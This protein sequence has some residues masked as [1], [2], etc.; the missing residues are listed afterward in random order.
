M[1]QPKIDTLHQAAGDVAV[2]VLQK[3]DA[4]FQAS[5]V[6]KSVNFLNERLPASS[7]GCA[8]PAKMNCTGRVASFSNRFKRSLSLNSSLARL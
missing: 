7:R 4:V 6:A 1:V 5:F 2:V 8:L 3:D